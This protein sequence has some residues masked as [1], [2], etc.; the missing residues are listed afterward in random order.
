VEFSEKQDGFYKATSTSMMLGDEVDEDALTRWSIGYFRRNILPHLP[1][2]KEAR[3]L[4]VG[5]GYGRHIKALGD[6]GYSHVLGIDLSEEQIAYGKTK[7]GLQN[8]IKED[9][10]VFLSDKENAYDAVLLLDVLEHFDI[11]PSIHLLQMIKRALKGEGVLII[12]CQMRLLL[13]RRVVTGIL[14]T[15]ERTST[16]SLTQSLRLAGF[17]HSNIAHY[18]LPLM[19]TNLKKRDRK[20]CLAVSAN[21]VHLCFLS[22]GLWDGHGRNLYTK[23]AGGCEEMKRG[24]TR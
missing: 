16:H 21:A 10:F 17:A 4:E 3:I 15:L 11:E 19:C 7:L 6:S 1:V 24:R 14:P 9:A 5:C 8:T 22:T 18:D 13:S 23:S 12:K 20:I 2:D